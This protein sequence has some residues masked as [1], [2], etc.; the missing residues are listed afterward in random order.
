MPYYICLSYDAYGCL[1]LRDVA[2]YFVNFCLSA[3]SALGIAKAKAKAKAKSVSTKC[4]GF[5]RG[6]ARKYLLNNYKSFCRAQ[7]YEFP[8]GLSDLNAWPSTTLLV[9]VML[10]VRNEQPRFYRSVSAQVR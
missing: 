4:S 2:C 7:I 5:P 1:T 3:L 8:R 10:L 9:P 6:R